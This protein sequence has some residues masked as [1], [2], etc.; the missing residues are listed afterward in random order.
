MPHFV[1]LTCADRVA[2]LGATVEELQKQLQ[3][4]EEEAN[5]VISQWQDS[6]NDAEQRCGEMEKELERLRDGA[7]SQ[8]PK[9]E[10]QNMERTPNQTRDQDL[11]AKIDNLELELAQ[12]TD[13]LSG[14]E[15]V[16]N[17]WEARV[18]ELETVVKSLEAKLEEQE[19]DSNKA[20]S[21]W[22]QMAS[23]A[24]ETAQGLEEKLSA[25][26]EE[27]FELLAANSEVEDERSALSE[28]LAELESR[29]GS[30]ENASRD[31]DELPSKLSKSE[32]ELAEA[33]ESLK[34]AEDIAHQ[35]EGTYA[36][37]AV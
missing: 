18:A 24:D 31:Q 12:A 21:E 28:K 37:F 34:E 16:V 26:L 6:Y 15:D 22:E 7:D 13:A 4:Q 10:G 29:L 14:D 9:A 23:A 35:W 19:R 2:E 3:E 20:I 5:G 1:V 36:A 8:S 33:K 30:T 32:E 27:K 25:L 17:Q 11:I